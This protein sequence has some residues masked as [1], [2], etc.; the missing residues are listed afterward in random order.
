MDPTE[1]RQQLAAWMDADKNR[2][3]AFV[4]EQVGTSQPAVSAWLRGIYRPE[5]PYRSALKLLAGIPEEAWLTSAERRALDE[6]VARIQSA[7]G[8]DGDR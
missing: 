2:T 3:Q 6:A 8:T 1:G 7:T 5:P 4:A